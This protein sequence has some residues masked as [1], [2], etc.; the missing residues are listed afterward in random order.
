MCG[1]PVDAA[2]VDFLLKQT[3]NNP[4]G[5]IEDDK[6]GYDTYPKGDDFFATSRKGSGGNAEVLLVGAHASASRQR[7]CATKGCREGARCARMGQPF[8]RIVVDQVAWHW[9]D[10]GAP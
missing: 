6:F 2:G 10:V 5:P 4:N 3:H 9:S 1:A 7:G 8:G